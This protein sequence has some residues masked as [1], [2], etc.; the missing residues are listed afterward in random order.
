M[1]NLLLRTLTG[2]IY[3]VV[4]TGGILGGFYTFLALFSVV[5]FACLWEFYGLINRQKS[6]RINRWHN[7]LGGVVLFVSAAMC[8]AGFVLPQIFLIYIMYIVSVFVLEVYGKGG[9]PMARLAAVLLGQVYIA[10]PLAVLPFLAFPSIFSSL[11][12]FGLVD[13]PTYNPILVLALFVFIWVNDTGAYLV[14]SRF[15]KHR[16]IER[17]SPLKSW[18]GFFGGILLTLAAAFVFAHFESGI[19]CYHWMGLALAVAIF[20]TWGDL[21]ESLIKRTLC[22][23]DSGRTLPGHGGFLDRFDS[24]LLGVYAV[25]GYLVLVVRV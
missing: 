15:G 18:E 14:G 10:L 6:L 8:A 19:S 12:S 22:V 9:D 16:L 3:V 23:K 1:K 17:I 2:A 7:G 4:I 11:I 20:A 21:I 25:L 5:A 13:L 24:F